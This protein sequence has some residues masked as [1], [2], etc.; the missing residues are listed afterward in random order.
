MVVPVRVAVP[1]GVYTALKPWLVRR[2]I[3]VL[4]AGERFRE[5]R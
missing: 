1:R 3:V 4:S 5:M 2:G